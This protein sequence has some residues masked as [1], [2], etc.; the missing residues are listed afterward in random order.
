MGRWRDADL[1]RIRTEIGWADRRAGT[2]PIPDTFFTRPELSNPGDYV[3][4]EGVFTPTDAL[5]FA[6]EIV[7]DRGTD[8]TARS[9]AGVLLNQGRSLSGSVEFREINALDARFLSAR[10]NLTVSEKYT[11]NSSMNFNF[12]EGDF[13]TFNAGI[14]RRFQTGTLGVTVSFNNIRGDTSIGVTYRLRGTSG[15]AGFGRGGDF[16]APDR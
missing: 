2:S 12:D 8:A 7:Y 15:G 14:R 6:G 1:L 13:Q 16:L 4:A 11:L 10:S 9:S 3:S 5:G